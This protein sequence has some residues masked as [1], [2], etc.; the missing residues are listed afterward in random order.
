MSLRHQILASRLNV[1]LEAAQ[2]ESV[3]EVVV[4]E[5]SE[6][7]EVAEDEVVEGSDE[8]VEVEATEEETEVPAEEPEVEATETEVEETE[9]EDAVEE[10]TDSEDEVAVD[11]DVVAEPEEPV[12]V[13]I[14]TAAEEILEINAAGDDLEEEEEAT[15]QVA[16]V[17]EGLESIALSMEQSLKVGGLTAIAAEG[18]DF[19][20]SAYCSRVGMPSVM[21]GLE[22]FGGS[23]SR[24]AQTQISIESIQEKVSQMWAA[25]LEMLEKAR[26]L[27]VEFFKKV[28]TNVGQLKAKA[29][30][31]AK[32]ADGLGVATGTSVAGSNVS[33]LTVGGKVPDNVAGELK[34]L[35]ELLEASYKYSD[36]ATDY[37]ESVGAGIAGLDA[38][39][40]EKFASGMKV[41]VEA[42][43]KATPQFAAASKDYRGE[44]VG[45]V[46][47]VGK[48]T[49]TFIGEVSVAALRFD[50]S[51]VDQNAQLRA[52]G[53]QRNIVSIANAAAVEKAPTLKSE[54]IKAI[55]AA[56]AEIVGTIEGFKDTAAK[57]DKSK[58]ALGKA[59]KAFE[60]NARKAEALSA[61]NKRLINAVLGVA[62]SVPGVVDQPSNKLTQ[63]T[64]SVCQAA[65]K[66]CSASI[67][68]YGKGEVATTEPA[69]A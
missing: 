13:M 9:V 61:E 68:A 11:A 33:K 25:I 43:T 42:T 34:K 3:D 35:G 23:G 21:P 57:V 18:Y 39:S 59:G 49:D 51:D 22:S 30:S 26:K 27:A 8:T 65:L 19:A 14:D 7:L 47:V 20:V 17:V 32:S 66:Y 31:I 55:A 36:E 63:H 29:A 46:G 69:T 4:E 6:E 24:L 48:Q 52:L 2:E 62:R 5:G 40:D 53:S 56:V 28:F 10:T 44:G 67:K 50:G 45:A 16:E 12:E 15:E 54:E 64:L 38:S 60:R 41:L 1:A 37:S 58:D